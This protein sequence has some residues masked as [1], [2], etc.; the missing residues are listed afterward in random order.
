M[1]A[2]RFILPKRPADG[3]DRYVARQTGAAWCVWDTLRDELVF[4]AERMNEEQARALA[5]QLSDAYRRIARYSGR[6]GRLG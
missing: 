6:S 3:A 5:R 4:G 1:R 2:A